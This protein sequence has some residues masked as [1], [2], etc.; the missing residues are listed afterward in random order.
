[1]TGSGRDS[2][3]LEAW[4]QTEGQLSLSGS[5]FCGFLFFQEKL[6]IFIFC[7]KISSDLHLNN[8]I[9]DQ[10]KTGR[11]VKGLLSLSLLQSRLAPAGVLTGKLKLGPRSDLAGHH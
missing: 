3:K 5:C 10:V 6:E 7:F 1:M 9:S 2:G 11:W 8:V 4:G